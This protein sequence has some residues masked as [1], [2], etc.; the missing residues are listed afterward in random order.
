MSNPKFFPG[1]LQSITFTMSE[2]EDASYPLANLQN[3]LPT[4]LWRSSNVNNNQSLILDFGADKSCDFVILEGHN[5]ASMVGVSLQAADDAAFSVNATTPVA[6]LTGVSGRIKVEFASVTRRYWR[7]R[8][9][10]TNSITPELG[11]IY[12]NAMLEITEGYDRPF[13]VGDEDNE[14][15]LGTSLSGL[16]RAS[17]TIDARKLIA[18]GF[19]NRTEAFRLAWQSFMSKIQG[20]LY[21]FYFADLDDNLYFVKLELD[22]SPVDVVKFEINTVLGVVMRE[23]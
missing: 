6:D 12:L 8:F 1:Q 4:E 23:Q 17:Q 21:V 22:Y 9:T 10:N 2:T 16:V 11:Q 19:S 18:I 15:S 7:L 13:Q 5:F 3:D 20:S 14:T